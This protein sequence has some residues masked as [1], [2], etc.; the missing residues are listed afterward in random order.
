MKLGCLGT[1]LA[2][3]ASVCVAFTP[4]TGQ[5]LWGS[6]PT[7]PYCINDYDGFTRDEYDSCRSDVEAYLRDVEDY[8]NCL[9]KEQNRV[10]DEANDVIDKFNCLASGE[11][12][13]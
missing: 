13:C 5:A 8:I 9:R 2:A 7:Q 6:E 4:T 1:V 10:S 11:S 12:Y 3:L